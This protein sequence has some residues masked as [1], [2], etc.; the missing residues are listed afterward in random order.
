MSDP[1]LRV[2]LLHRI[3]VA[4]RGGCEDEADILEDIPELVDDEL[5]DSDDDLVDDLTAEA[6][7]LI[8]EQRL[9]EDGWREA[10]LNDAIDRAFD[11]LNER[12]IIA[13]QNAGY[14][15]SEG[16]SDANELASE[17][18]TPP[19]GAVFYHGQDLERA[20]EG[21]GLMLAFGAYSEDPAASEAVAGEVVQTLQRHGVPVQWNG[22]LD[23]RLEI[24][25]FEWRKRRVTHSPH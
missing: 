22:S 20:V 21:G 10:N 5:G 16:W 7:R 19:R 11:E 12:G 8:R 23:R 14:T 15:T 18:D 25:P 24:P 6:H 17:Q 2:H 13:L 3:E 4:V 9:R 1:S